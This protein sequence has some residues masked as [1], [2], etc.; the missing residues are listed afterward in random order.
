[1]YVIKGDPT[2]TA[3]GHEMLARLYEDHAYDAAKEAGAAATEDARRCWEELE[4]QADGTSK[5]HAFRAE[6]LRY[7]A[8]GG[9][10]E[11]QALAKQRAEAGPTD[12][13]A[14]PGREPSFMGQ[15]IAVWPNR[16]SAAEGG[17][18]YVVGVDPGVSSTA[19]VRMR[20]VDGV[21]VECETWDEP[22]KGDG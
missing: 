1:M 4:A 11:A 7:D 17:S 22:R 13:V 16:A 8:R 2:L 10:T 21:V 18:R 5:G 14:P 15:P 3:K 9:M 12:L 20:I 6:E 19:V